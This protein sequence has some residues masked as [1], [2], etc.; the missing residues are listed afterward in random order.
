MLG[1]NA[2]D[3]SWSSTKAH[4][5]GVR[6]GILSGNG[7]LKEE[8]LEIYRDFLREED[9]EIE[10]VIRKVTSTGRPLGT[11]RF[12]KRLEKILERDILPKKAGRPK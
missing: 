8:K 5:L 10:S 12:I 7:W 4:V 1:K 11:E 2:E 3:Y 6:D 9:K